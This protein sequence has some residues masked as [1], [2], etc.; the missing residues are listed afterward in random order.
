M[1][2]DARLRLLRVHRSGSTPGG[3]IRQSIQL[4]R[5]RLERSARDD[6]GIAGAWN[7]VA[8]GSLVGRATVTGVR[9]GVLTIRCRSASDRF[10]LDRWLRSGGEQALR[11]E[12]RVAFSRVRLVL[13]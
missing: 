13:R 8:P 10:A 1:L 11:R 2:P 4:Q 7:R 9:G 6:G 5:A 12:A 3:S